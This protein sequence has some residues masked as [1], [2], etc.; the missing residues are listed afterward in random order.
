MYY[1]HRAAITQIKLLYDFRI[2]TPPK[3][4]EARLV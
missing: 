2:R 1:I 4:S 3:R